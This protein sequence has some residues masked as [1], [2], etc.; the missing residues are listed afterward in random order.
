MYDEVRDPL[1]DSSTQSEN[2]ILRE[3]E[4]VSEGQPDSTLK[5]RFTD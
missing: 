5:K 1:S 4:E 3:E 2:L